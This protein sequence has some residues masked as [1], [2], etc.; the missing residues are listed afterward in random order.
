M[1]DPVPGNDGF[2]DT[3]HDTARRRRDA[4]TGIADARTPVITRRNGESDLYPGIWPTNFHKGI[5]HDCFGRPD[6]IA[7]AEFGTA[8]SGAAIPAGVYA[9]FNVALGP[10]GET[11]A[12]VSA[13]RAGAEEGFVP[14]VRFHTVLA[15][16]QNIRVRNWESP[17]AGHVYDLQGPDA[18]DVGIAPAPSLQGGEL[19]AEMAEVY[20]LA[21]LRDTPFE[22]WSDPATPVVVDGQTLGTV[23]VILDDLGRL[24]FLDPAGDPGFPDPQGVRRREARWQE[25][26]LP[27]SGNAF[28]GSSPGSKTGPYLSQFLLIGSGGDGGTP[29][30]SAKDVRYLC[31]VSAP[32]PS[33]PTGARGGYI[34]Y[35]A[36]RI[37][38][39]V[40]A[41]ASG[42]DHMTDWT[43]WLDVQNGAAVNG[44]DAFEQ[45]GR[46]RFVN[47]PRDLAT[48]VHFD[49]LY[50]AYLNACLLLFD[51]KVP[52]DFGLPSGKGHVTRGSFATFGGPHVLALLTEVSSRALK[53]V[54][55]QKFQHH[56]RGRPEQ[57]AAMLTLAAN[58]PE[59]LGTA[60][61]DTV[62]ALN[63]LLDRAPDLM[64][65]VAARNARQNARRSDPANRIFPAGDGT[66][67][68]FA[69]D[70]ART[71]L[72][73][74]AFPEGS[75]M[76]PAYGAGHATV[77]GACVTV[78]KAFFELS[79]N[80]VAKP[81]LGQPLPVEK[82]VEA[83]WW[84]MANFSDRM[85][86]RNVY[87][88]P[89]DP[90][91]AALD[92]SG[93][94]RPNEL[95]IEGELNKLA[96]NI[97]IGRNMGGV[98]FYSDYYDSLRMGERV[99]V[100]ILQE[101]MTSYN[102]PC[103]MRLP[104]FDGDRLVVSTTGRG[105]G[106]VQVLGGD[107]DEW[108]NRHVPGGAFV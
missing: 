39:R 27:S 2:N 71:Y 96:A 1:V 13:N 68:G 46:P 25:G 85:K 103:S 100:G 76:H 51:Y 99:A 35:G 70:D 88:P 84:K 18:G 11:G 42:L 34:A 21:L 31:P 82:T 40:S 75:P 58:A 20:A 79:P 16:G 30:D 23:G 90:W 66:N 89:A 83:Q 101:Q 55:R 5:P 65:M 91:A 57:V 36:Q 104:T 37:D 69:P 56:L 106:T 6:P 73:P 72:L 59:A 32:D 53:A 3:R 19:V 29:A 7:F 50:Q 22:T 95:T 8:L 44:A 26:A 49:Q 107:A 4:A 17:L 78:L 60:Q 9:P 45:G 62:N 87:V 98:H 86:L 33:M 80:E 81:G 61:G 108:W 41:A 28:R 74:M 14:V 47:T 64:D 67:C 15:D 93:E 92:A 77:A 94:F 105:D 52:F 38:Q 97:S 24:D 12:N 54:R 63:A 48:Y 43:L 10:L 102:D